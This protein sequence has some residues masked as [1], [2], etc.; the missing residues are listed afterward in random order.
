MITKSLN[1]EPLQ[2]SCSLNL[3]FLPCNVHC[4]CRNANLVKTIWYHPRKSA[5]L[6]GQLNYG[7]FTVSFLSIKKSIRSFLRTSSTN[8]SSRYK[9]AR[10]GLLYSY[11][12]I[13]AHNKNH[14][15]TFTTF[16]HRI[17]KKKIF[18]TMD[19]PLFY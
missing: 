12:E 18:Y 4:R 16:Y 8:S 13:N 3:K 19:R 7:T 15:C 5:P 1:N 14:H 9:C 10:A 6:H 2:L 17:D 11:H